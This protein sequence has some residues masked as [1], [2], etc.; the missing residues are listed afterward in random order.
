VLLEDDRNLCYSDEEWTALGA[1]RLNKSEIA[2]QSQD[3]P[4]GLFNSYT[5]N[6][7]VKKNE[8]PYWSLKTIF[9]DNEGRSP[10]MSFSTHPKLDEFTELY[11]Y[12]GLQIDRHVEG[13]VDAYYGP[14][15]IKKRVQSEDLPSPDQLGHN[16]KLL[17]SNLEDTSY[18]DHRTGYLRKQIIAMQT[19][20]KKLQKEKI[21]YLD[22]VEQC[23]DIRPKRTDETKFPEALETLEELVPGTGPLTDRYE[24]Y[25]TQFEIPRDNLLS[26]IKL[27][28][29][30]V[31]KKTKLTVVGSELPDHEGVE[32]SIVENQP[33]SAYNWYLGQAQ[34][35]IE[36]DITP[37]KNA[38]VI[39][40]TI[41]HE[42]YPGHHTEHAI[43][44]HLLYHQKGYGENAMQL[45]LAPESLVSEGIA[46]YGRQ[47]IFSDQEVLDWTN[48]HVFPL[49][50]T[51]PTFD[52]E[53][54][55]EIANAA[56]V[57][58]A[59]GSHLAFLLHVDGLS[60]D[61]VVKFALEN[62]FL[63][64]KRIQT[65]LL[66]VQDP[67]WRSYIFNYYYGEYLVR[68]HVEQGDRLA[69]F[70]DLLQAQYWPS[71]LGSS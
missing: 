58:D 32:F 46:N 56:K 53:T 24:T 29:E 49:L 16:V 18:D 64:E 43:K 61:E 70:Q 21:S 40:D 45:T 12:L 8:F 1:S 51:R 15:E 36:V 6:F 52:T 22:E 14:P 60:T 42:C 39:L 65:H 47:L 25:R 5:Q 17:M 10:R 44:E 19:I 9:F 69:R 11:L 31:Q 26:I 38:L 59:L 20:I 55:L 62:T 28:C 35:K 57:F 30:I 37:P 4:G 68:K 13:F 48:E 67:L 66:F 3:I 50:P 2:A 33:W 27:T 34:S 7:L 23:F 54:Q 63:T 41:A 71:L